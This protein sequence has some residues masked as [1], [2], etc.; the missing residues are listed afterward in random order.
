LSCSHQEALE[1]FSR[2]NP[3]HIIIL[4]YDESRRNEGTDTWLSFLEH[5]LVREVQEV[6][7]YGYKKYN[8]SNYRTFPIEPL[9]LRR[10]LIGH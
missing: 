8:L 6:I 3:S 2:E 9:E 10:D 1:V 7:L 5:A 4:E